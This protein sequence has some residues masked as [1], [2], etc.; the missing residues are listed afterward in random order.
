LRELNGL[1]GQQQPSHGRMCD[2][3]TPEDIDA[4][5]IELARRIEAFVASQPDEETTQ[6]PTD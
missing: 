3:D 5:R 6:P 2:C 1:L 4:F